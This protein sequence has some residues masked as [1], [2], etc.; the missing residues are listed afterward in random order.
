MAQRL[1]SIYMTNDVIKICDARKSGNSV[2][3]VSAFEVEMPGGC[4]N[5]G[6]ITDTVVLAEGIRSGMEM[7]GMKKGK[8]VFTI[9][10]KKIANKEIVV[11]FVKNRAKVGEII[12]ANLDEYF[13]MNN[14]QD[15]I[16]KHTIL[17]A[18]E[19]AEG[20]HYSV[21]VTAV[22]KE[23]IAAY[24]ELAETLN[25]PIETIDYYGNSIYNILQKQLSAGIVLALQMD[26]DVTYVN[27]MKGQ[28]Q[29]FRRA[30][31]FGRDT[32]I[33]NMA[34]SQGVSK[35]EALHILE[36]PHKLDETVSAEE[37]SEMVRDFTSA[38]MRVVEF[39][40]TRNAGTIIELGKLMGEGANIIGL[41]EI[42]TKDLGVP[43]TY[44]KQLNGIKIKKTK[45]TDL[46]VEQLAA[47]L[48]NMGAI[49]HSLDLK[50]EAEK[51][52]TALGDYGL[53]YLLIA[54]TAVAA[55]AVTVT[56]TLNYQDLKS[57]KAALEASIAQKGEIEQI[58]Q[59]YTNAKSTYDAISAYDLATAN[60][61]E[62]LYTWLGELEK[63]IPEG[64]GIT[65]LSIQDGE[66]TLTGTSTSKQ[67]ISLLISELKEMPQ[68]TNIFLQ[69]TS[70]VYDEDGNATTTFNMNLH[71]TPSVV[72]ELPDT[73]EEAVKE[74]E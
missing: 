69:S 11:P 26:R 12:Q 13:P 9:S 46:N 71:I 3:A 20:K 72:S 29:L 56:M 28:A 2:S 35:R 63:V 60:D 58:F 27:I 21:S 50:P 42:L 1:V 39:H 33:Q 31:P 59:D 43:V 49:M 70:D 57:Q 65:T 15:Y 51:K 47:Y 68:I 4:F 6:M 62:A 23:M 44:V 5:D 16:C 41:A 52:N 38:I 53:Y 45:N 19:N 17:D 7:N 22:Q 54:V 30:V 10:S 40:T 34:Q 8:L 18:F 74:G 36:D 64:V 25:M 24:Y 67:A 14:M 61:T 73:M 37:Y 48:P 55:I 32:L 66:I